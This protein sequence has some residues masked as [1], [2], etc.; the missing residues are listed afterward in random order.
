[1]SRP[2]PSPGVI[3]IGGATDP[4]RP[5]PTGILTVPGFTGRLKVVVTVCVIVDAGS[6]GGQAL[7]GELGRMVSVGGFPDVDIGR[8]TVLYSTIVVGIGTETVSVW[9]DVVLK[10][11][12][13]VSVSVAYWVVV[14]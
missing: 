5:G 9:V 6:G 7:P 3:R 2:S 13:S 4:I 1:M 12:V 14:S 8:Y 11:P 10:R